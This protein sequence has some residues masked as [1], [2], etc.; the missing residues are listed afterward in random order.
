MVKKVLTNLLLQNQESF[1]A[2]LWHKHWGLKVYQSFS[3][4]DPRM[5]FDCIKAWSNLCPNCFSNTVRIMHGNSC[6]IRVSE[7][8]PMGLLFSF[9]LFFRL[10]VNI[11]HIFNSTDIN[12][13][14]QICV[15][16]PTGRSNVIA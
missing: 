10:N 9:F 16:V 15:S 13:Y 6:V 14:S 7:L 3:N 2:E 1:E 5:T 11:S 4:D 8:W 12:T